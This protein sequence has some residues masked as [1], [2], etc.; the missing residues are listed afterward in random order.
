MSGALAPPRLVVATECPTC[1]APLYFPEGATTVRCTHCRS[2]L[3]LTG[4]GRVLA[5][6]VTPRLEERAALEIARTHAARVTDAQLYFLPY[7]RFTGEEFRWEMADREAA[8]QPPDLEAGGAP[9]ELEE[10]CL[11]RNFLAC[12]WDG[13]NLYSLGVRPGVL[14][15]ALFRR[16]TLT[17]V[18]RVVAADM[19]PDAALAH[20]LRP[21]D[22]ERIVHRAVLGGALSLVYYPYWAMTLGGSA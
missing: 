3:L 8:E 6:H 17:Q 10:R 15:L 12:A 1:A 5:F 21:V 14:R 19:A 4:R 18:G 16:E 11:E 13:L 20:A 7:Y 22:G 2:R 9:L